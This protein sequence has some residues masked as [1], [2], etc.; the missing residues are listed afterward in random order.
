VQ[1]LGV[2]YLQNSTAE[3]VDKVPWVDLQIMMQKWTRQV[4]VAVKVLY[5]GERRL[6]RQVFR[7]LGQPVWVECLS[8]VAQPGMTAFLQFGESVS[9]SSRSPEKLC[10]LLEMVEGLEKSEHSVIQVF[11]GQACS[12]IRS[13]YRELLKQVNYPITCLC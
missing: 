8:H 6:A 2:E 1:V 5:A 9:K 10:K 4:E 7:D 3:M 13:R 12:G 11:D